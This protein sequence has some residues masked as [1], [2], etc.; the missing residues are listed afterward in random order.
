[1]DRKKKQKKIYNNTKDKLSDKLSQ[2]PMA[3]DKEKTEFQAGSFQ[4]EE[5]PV[6]KKKQKNRWQQNVN[7]NNAKYK[8]PNNLSGGFSLPLD[9]ELPQLNDSS[10]TGI[11]SGIKTTDSRIKKSRTMKYFQK[12]H[13]ETDKPDTSKKEPDGFIQ[14]Q[15]AGKQEIPEKIHCGEG[16]QF[17]EEKLFTEENTGT[18]KDF[19]NDSPGTAHS[20][21]DIYYS[22]DK[23][24]SYIK[25]HIRKK[26]YQDY[27]SIKKK[28]GYEKAED[29]NSGKKAGEKTGQD[30]L[31]SGFSDKDNTFK[32][33]EGCFTGSRKFEKLQEKSEKAGKRLEKVKEK[34]PKETHYCSGQAFW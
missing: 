31:H 30:N 6:K 28:Q 27:G 18:G 21:K 13:H 33:D 2:S 4:K 9:K 16:Q 19:Y 20:Q 17:C 12:M 26:Q 15:C 25:K 34:L 5:E 8:P 1:M 7:Y 32:E 14:E 24:S 29:K 11:N 23:K 22:T 3:E 10:F